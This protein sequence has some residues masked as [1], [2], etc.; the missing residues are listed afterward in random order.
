MKVSGWKVGRFLVGRFL[1]GGLEGFWQ[2]CIQFNVTKM[3]A[4]LQFRIIIL[5]KNLTINTLKFY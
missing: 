1:V 5:F 4:L 2:D 3:Q